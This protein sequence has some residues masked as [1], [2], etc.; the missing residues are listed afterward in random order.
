MSE[1]HTTMDMPNQI[2]LRLIG[3][4]FELKQIPPRV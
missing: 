2:C 3:E 1:D 4:Y